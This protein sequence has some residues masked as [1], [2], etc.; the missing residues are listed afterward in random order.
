MNGAQEFVEDLV[1]SVRPPRGIAIA[2][3]ERKPKTTDDTNWITGTGPLPYA[4]LSRYN[5]AIAELSRQHSRIDWTGITELNGERRR[6]ARW[7]SEV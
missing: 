4:A 3:T 1:R 5:S 2:L 6:I 7:F